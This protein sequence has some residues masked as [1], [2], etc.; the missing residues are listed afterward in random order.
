MI[1][2]IYKWGEFTETTRIKEDRIW[3]CFL[4]SKRALCWGQSVCLDQGLSRIKWISELAYEKLSNNDTMRQL[5]AT[6]NIWRDGCKETDIDLFT[7]LD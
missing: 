4:N 3:H 2:Y 6:A 7:D 1:C 5:L